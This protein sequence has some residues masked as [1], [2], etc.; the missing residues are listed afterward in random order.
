MTTI[1]TLSPPQLRGS[2]LRRLGPAFVPAIAY[3]DPG[4]LVTNVTAGARH[5]TALLWVVVLATGV[6]GP[7]QYLAAKLGATTGRTLPQLVAE[8]C[9]APW[10]VAYWAQAE[11]VSIA[12]DVAEVIGAAIAMRLLLGIPLPLG[13]LIAAG[14]GA[15]LLTVG[16][17]L[18]E[19]FLQSVSVVSLGIIGGAFAFCLAFRPPPLHEL[20]A[21][22]VP[23]LP[24]EG[25]L[26]L[27]AG[28]VGATIMP[29]AI[30]IH[31]A[32]A[33]GH[34]RL[35]AHRIDVLTAMLFAGA[36][37]AAMLVVGAGALRGMAGDDFAGIAEGLAERAGSAARTAFLTALLVSGLTSTA[38]GTQS[39]SVVMSGLLRREMPR[40][41]RRL[42]TVLPAVVLLSVG[43]SPSW[44][45]S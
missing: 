1:Q 25:A 27:A 8:H 14:V 10:R 5:G 37:N 42:A 30:H 28:I 12:T 13:G 11:L 36:T 7:V 21:G 17:Q 40:S 9:P 3:V 32:L 44:C 4:N 24:G 18:G 45:S 35:D 33:R 31:S 43:A 6:A 34:H 2:V 29:H 23:A 41:V 22:L 15:G 38:V 26:V 20:G 19:R 39:G 16:D